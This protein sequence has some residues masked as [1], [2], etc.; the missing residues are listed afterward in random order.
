MTL[1]YF[2]EITEKHAYLGGKGYALGRLKN[3]G[4]NVPDGLILDAVPTEVEFEKIMSWWNEH[5]NSPLA[6]RSSAVGEDSSE[7]SFA[8]QNS[9]FLNVMNR[10]ELKE[11]IS[12]CFN[13]INKKSSV[14]YR[15]HFLKNTEQKNQ[16][17]V[18]I[19]LM[20]DPFVS[21][22]FFSIDPRTN[23]DNWIVEAIVG[24]GEDLVSGKKTP[25]HFEQLKNNTTDIF[26]LNNLVNVGNR[27]RDFFKLEI[28]MEWAISKNKELFVLQARPITALGGKS[29]EKRMI[30]AEIARLKKVYP[31]ETIWDGSTFAEWSGAPTELSFSI[32]KEAFAKNHSFSKALQILGYL[33]INEELS[34]ESHSLL[35]RIFD[36]AYV[37]ISMMAPLYFGPIPYRLEML[38]EPKLKFD[39]K[40]MNFKTFIQTPITIFRMIKVSFTMSSERK[41]WLNQANLE[42]IKFKDIS[43]RSKDLTRYA[44]VETD[45]LFNLFQK[46]VRDFYG[47]HLIWPL[48]LIS[49]IES[50]THGLKA[51]LKGVIP[52]L[53]IDHKFNE[54]LGRGIHTITMDMNSEYQK[55]CTN[56]ELRPLFFEKYGHRG[57]GELELSHPRWI[58]LN[59][60][61]FFT[62]QNKTS[63]SIKKDERLSVEDEIKSLK[64]LKKE[65]IL[66]EWL[67]LKEMLELRERFKMSLL[68]PYAHI[69]FITLE[70]Q[71][72]F[73]L[74][75]LIFW[76]NF[77]EIINRDFDLK[78]AE[79][80][81][82]HSELSK[83]LYLPKIVQLEKIERI[84]NSKDVQGSKVQT[85]EALSPGLVYGEIRVVINPETVQTDSWPQNTILVA[86]S[87]DPG[88]T[89]L[90]LKSKA[91]IVE[92][93]GVLS[94][95]AIVAREMNLPAISGIKQCHLKFKDGEKVWVDGNNGRVTLA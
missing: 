78:R 66:K 21:G 87:T 16:M 39:F 3:A 77:E 33:G 58:E 73:N 20:V 32:W 80:R 44:Q 13:S 46:E 61:A 25:W 54:W 76:H 12:N 75:D 41:F 6:V 43:F 27:V 22:V 65:V 91:V 10:S 47:H 95:C 88:W 79:K 59:E 5:F 26:D 14:I 40:K 24:L 17:N 83:S 15:D 82:N 45:E 67:L 63:Q 4:F 49:L 19:Q 11:A 52:D 55:A 36:R 62:V 92:K 60:K 69:R 56:T 35:E 84:I 90:F 86:E 74:S 72:R 57:P 42:L 48:V 64:T 8:G 51:L 38:P 85:G 81:K 31:S 70:I 71:K 53:E 9:T 29:E 23:K 34:N 28:D 37:N 18:V 2:D 30:E 1:Y 93:G 68:S 7:Q 94:H 89:G 50:T